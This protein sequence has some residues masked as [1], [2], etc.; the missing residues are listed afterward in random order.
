M[1]LP[2]Y[3][4]FY[5]PT[6]R[7][8]IWLPKGTRHTCPNTRRGPNWV[9]RKVYPKTEIEDPHPFLLT[10]EIDGGPYEPVEG[11]DQEG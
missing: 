10:E 1:P 9:K 7:C 4:E 5:C 6:C 3:D 11:S 8:R 2:G